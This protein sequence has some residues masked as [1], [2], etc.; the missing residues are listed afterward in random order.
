MTFQSNGS[1]H[2]NLTDEPAVN[3]HLE[4]V[5]TAFI[6]RGAAMLESSREP[7]FLQILGHG[8]DLEANFEPSVLVLQR[9]G[10]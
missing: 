4:W 5:N 1:R 6:Q 9:P 10:K 8:G 7:A 3:H 2:V